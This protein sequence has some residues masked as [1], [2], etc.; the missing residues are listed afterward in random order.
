MV[1]CR[2]DCSGYGFGAFMLARVH[3]EVCP[4]TCE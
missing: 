4:K 1:V 3:A 2:F